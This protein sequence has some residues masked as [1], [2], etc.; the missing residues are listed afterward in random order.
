MC[1][2]WIQM[3]FRWH[4]YRISCVFMGFRQAFMGF[5]V[6]SWDL[7][8]IYMGFHLFSWDLDGID[9]G[10]R[11]DWYGNYMEMFVGILYVL[12]LQPPLL[13]D[14]LTVTKASFLGVRLW[15]IWIINIGIH[16][17]IY[18]CLIDKWWLVNDFLGGVFLL[19]NPSFIVYFGVFGMIIVGSHDDTHIQ[20][21]WSF[22]GLSAVASSEDW[23]EVPKIGRCSS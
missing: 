23:M 22:C 20:R 9:I 11:W 10:F 18:N 8:G 17:Y 6:F 19:G 12:F 4:L 7:D 3:G 21:P 13:V 2:P 14:D 16:I 15:T 5:H 1:F